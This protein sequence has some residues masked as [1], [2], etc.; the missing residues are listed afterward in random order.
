MPSATVAKMLDEKFGITP[1][2]KQYINEVA[3]RWK[4]NDDSAEV[5]FISSVS[6]PF[7]GNCSRI[8][9]STDGKLYTCL[10]SDLGFDIKP[11]LDFDDEEQLKNKIVQIWGNRTDQY[12]QKRFD[13]KRRKLTK[14]IEMYA[15]GG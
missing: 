15:I 8:R 14:K 13:T 7:C 5:G 1:L 10:F 4:Y 11:A 9:L 12:S 6:D 2:E 3:N